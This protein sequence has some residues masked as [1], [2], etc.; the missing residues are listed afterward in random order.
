MAGR[1]NRA[2]DIG[3]M[4]GQNG[5]NNIEDPFERDLAFRSLSVTVYCKLCGGEILDAEQDST[6]ARVN[7]QYETQVGAH[8]SCIEKERRRRAGR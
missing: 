8:Q 6:G 5:F 1:K 7:W 3:M 2:Q 4:P